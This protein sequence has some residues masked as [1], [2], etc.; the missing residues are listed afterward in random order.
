M[1]AS[2]VTP[3]AKTGGLADV[4]AALTAHL[5]RRDHDVRLFM[6]LYRRVERGGFKFE[7]VPALT[8]IPIV[9]GATTYRFTVFTSP[10]PRSKTVVNFLYCAELFGRDG[11]YTLDRDE[12]L[13]FGLFTRAVLE[14]CQR[15]AFAPDVFHLNDWHSALLPLY[16]R[17]PY[18]WDTLF[19]ASKT[20]LTIHNIG[21]QGVFPAEGVADLGLSEV[22]SLLYQEDLERGVL[23]YLKTGILYADLINTVSETYARE[24]Q[25]EELGMGLHD[26]LKRRS[27]SLVGVLNGVDY[28]EWSPERDEQ[29]PFHYSIDELGGKAR[30]KRA[31]LDELRLPF[32]RA[33]PVFGIV[34]RL[35]A[36]KGFDLLFQVLPPLLAERDV[37]VCVL[38]S[39]EER[40]ERFFEALA[41]EHP[42]KLG[43]DRTFNDRLAHL[44]EA[45]SDLFLMPSRYEP[46][47]LNQMYSL[48]Y[49]TVPIVRRT[50]GLADTVQPFDPKTG[51]G[52]G[53]VFDHYNADG[54]RWAITRALEIWPD[55]RAWSRLM[56]NG[57]E[58][59]Y[60]WDHQ[61]ERYVELYARLT[62]KR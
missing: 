23:N 43:Y 8:D 10:L 38:G 21:Y 6:P 24:I 52:T 9:A 55:K 27:D 30:N 54:L 62:G 60:S 45:G 5:S 37:R 12:H 18:A 59:D 19:R 7:R 2:E 53:F 42:T 13:R 15:L 29:I 22:R 20:L 61:T 16:L 26:L 31:L 58:R 1:L 51:A 46:C 28:D 50:G 36:Q 35:T 40:Y 48:R 44:I 3:F 32:D 49:G 47:G 57:M 33:A 34:S 17:G 25:T 11:L 14:C 41:R 56:R 4:S 39:G